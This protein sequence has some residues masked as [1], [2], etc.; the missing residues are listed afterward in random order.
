MP[1][2]KTK[3]TR[4]KKERLHGQP[5]PLAAQSHNPILWKLC[6]GLA[7][8]VFILYWR[9]TANQFIT[10]DDGDYITLNEHVKHG[11][12]SEGLRWAFGEASNGNWHPL[13]WITHM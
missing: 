4:A 6:A 2:T 5:A 12:T 9:V 7:A 3:G 8:V 1:P 10:F 11:F 13:T